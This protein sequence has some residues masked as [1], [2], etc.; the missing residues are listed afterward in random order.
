LRKRQRGGAAVREC[1]VSRCFLD[2]RARL[3]NS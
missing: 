3:L 1:G 2:A